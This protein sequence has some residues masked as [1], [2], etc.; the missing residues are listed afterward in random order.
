M[1][2]GSPRAYDVNNYYRILEDPISGIFYFQYK[3]YI[4][5][6]KTYP[7]NYDNLPDVKS[8]LNVYKEKVET[9]TTLFKRHIIHTI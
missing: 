1:A 2:A 6:W 5:F 9:R 3:T 8:A 7:A 4:F